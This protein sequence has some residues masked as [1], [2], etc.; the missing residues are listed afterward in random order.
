[1][2]NT[3]PSPGS[4]WAPSGRRARSAA[5]TRLKATMVSASRRQVGGGRVGSFV[6][7]RLCV[8]RAACIRSILR[9]SPYQGDDHR[10]SDIDLLVDADD[11][12]GLVALAGVAGSSVTFSV[13]RSMSFP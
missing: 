13:L 5:G 1:M 2:A 10:G 12:V 3:N 11:G 4:P 8:D 6:I 7:R 9:R